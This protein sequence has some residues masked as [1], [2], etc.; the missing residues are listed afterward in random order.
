MNNLKTL[1]KDK[2]AKVAIVGLGYV[3]LPLAIALTEKGFH[4]SG[5]D[6]Q[7]NKV[8]SINSGKSYIED[9]PSSTL[10]KALDN[11]K[12]TAS[13][14]KKIFRNVDIIIICV[15]SPL[16]KYKQPDISYI[17]QTAKDIGRFIKKGQLVI[18]E[19]TTYPGT[20]REVILPQLEKSGLKVGKDFYLAF[21]PERID[22]GNKKYTVE[23][24]P[25]AVGGITDHC[26]ELTALF[27]Q[28]FI[29]KVITLS[30]PEAAEMTK[31]LENIFRVVNISMINEL[32]LLCGKMGIDIWE[33]IE[34]AKTK[35]FGFM[36]FYPSP[37]IG[38]HCI[39]QDPFYLSWKAKEH[40]FYAR[41]IEL[42]AQINEQMPHYVVT[43]VIW[44]LNQDKKS[45]KG[46]KIL[47]WGVSYKKNVGDTRE[48]AAHDIIWDLERKGARVNYFDPY[49]KEFIPFEK[50]AFD[51]KFSPP[52]HKSIRYRPDVLKEYDCV[53]I[54]TDHSNANYDTIAQNAKVVVDTRNAIKNRKYK[55]VVWL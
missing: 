46:A 34:A 14:D 19:S 52:K 9:V 2:K 31:L 53:L 1:I 10:K 15:P 21:S 7:K 30:S 4:V 13:T 44:A 51:K 5:L 32:A 27:Y 3:G 54:L 42:A 49:V 39:A 20:T 38:G 43:K 28:S 48:S 17:R 16:D 55:N 40:N 22:P 29:N 12:L 26:S 11:K 25:K 41:F 8:D 36:P 23:N 50:T 37:K 45:V 18:L 24:I 33:V 47:I 35:P 6:I